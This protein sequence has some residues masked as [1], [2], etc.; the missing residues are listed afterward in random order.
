V[1]EGKSLVRSGAIEEGV[2]SDRE[3]ESVHPV[4]PVF[5]EEVKE[6]NGCE[7]QENE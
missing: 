3:V 1:T 5:L 6:E 4:L 7:S 2:E